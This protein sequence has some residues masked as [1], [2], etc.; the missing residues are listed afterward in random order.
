MNNYPD[1]FNSNG[2]RQPAVDA[3][4]TRVSQVMKRVYLKMFLG[5]LVTAL[6]SFFCAGS[7]AVLSFYAQHSWMIWGLFIAELVLVFAISG[8]INRM[9]AS[10]ATALFFLFAVINGLAVFAIFIVYTH[11]SIAKTFFITA[12]TFGAMSIYGYF[13]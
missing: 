2:S 12:G 10:T 13:T 11:V 4:D 7:P 3:L 8:G 6:V 9:Q 1:Y 5:L